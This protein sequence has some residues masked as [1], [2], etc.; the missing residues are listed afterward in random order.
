MQLRCR[1]WA[2]ILLSWFPGEYAEEIEC[3]QQEGCDAPRRCHFG[4]L[5]AY[6]N[7]ARWLYE[8]TEC[9]GCCEGTSPGCCD[10]NAPAWIESYGCD[11]HNRNSVCGNSRTRRILTYPTHNLRCEAEFREAQLRLEKYCE[12]AYVDFNPECCA[13]ISCASGFFVDQ[14]ALKCDT[15]VRWEKE[16]QTVITIYVVIATTLLLLT[17]VAD[18]AHS[19]VLSSILPSQVINQNRQTSSPPPSYTPPHE[20]RPSLKEHY[21]APPTGQVSFK[22]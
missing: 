16:A 17:T 11:L 21:T 9:R 8:N 6:N 10:T 7:I 14:H 12:E 3:N 13:N 18:R 5:V 2:I 22:L 1:V 19:I 20:P 4:S 15:D